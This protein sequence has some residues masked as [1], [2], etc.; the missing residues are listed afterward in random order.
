MDTSLVGFANLISGILLLLPWMKKVGVPAGF[1]GFV[2]EQIESRRDLLGTVDLGLGLV[3]LANRMG[4]IYLSILSSSYPQSLVLLGAGLTVGSHF[5][6]GFKPARDLTKKL[7]PYR[8]YVGAAG[9]LLGL[10][11][12]F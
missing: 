6:K 8:D 10:H 9:V 11:A 12:I 3:S 4:L 2:H 1:T 7:E 5:A